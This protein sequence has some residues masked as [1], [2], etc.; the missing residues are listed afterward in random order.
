MP[1][2]PVRPSSL[3]PCPPALHHAAGVLKDKVASPG[4][5]TIAG[6]SALEQAGVRGAFMAAVSSAAKRSQELSRQ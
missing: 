1:Q 5:T 3:A 2:A 6:I 4:G